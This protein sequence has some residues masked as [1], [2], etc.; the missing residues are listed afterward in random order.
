VAS[1]FFPYY[2]FL[3]QAGLFG[4]EILTTSEDEGL[5]SYN[6]QYSGMAVKRVESVVYTLEPGELDKG[7]YQLYVTVTDLTNG[8]IDTR[9]L[10]FFVTD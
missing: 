9:D 6:E 3:A 2:T 4:L 8:S 1:A 10:R 7:V 5:S